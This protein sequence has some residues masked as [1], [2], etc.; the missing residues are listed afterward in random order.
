MRRVF[1][2]VSIA[3]HSVVIALVVLAQVFDIGALPTPRDVL[4]FV[5][6]V[7]IISPPLPPPP[8]PAAPTAA[9]H[10][11]A[12]PD[13]APV[14]APRG[15]IP[16][17]ALNGVHTERTDRGIVDNV[18]R[19]GSADFGTIGHSSSVPTP[20]PPAPPTQPVRIFGGIRAPRK[21]V[22]VQPEYPPLARAAR[23]QGIVILE[24]VID[25]RGQVDSVRVLRG[26]PLLDQAAIDAVKQWR[27]TPT[28]LNGQPIP[29]VMTVTVN[30]VLDVR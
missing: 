16:E 23:Q 22:D 26:Y 6:P 7:T 28:L 9:S 24:T 30:F 8:Q 14:E 27:F 10:P 18:E 4:A 5:R 25:A 13:A 1:P 2:F 21:I 15:V 3:I 11:G 12:A 29:V 17:T 19:G 20:P